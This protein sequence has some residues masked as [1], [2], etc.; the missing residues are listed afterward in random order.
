MIK[1]GEVRSLKKRITALLLAMIMMFGSVTSVYAEAVTESADEE[2]EITVDEGDEPY[3]AF[4]AD[5]T[6]SEK[7]KV[8]DLMGITEE[9]LENYTVVTVTNEQEHEYLGAYIPSSTIGSRAL[10][11]VLVMQGEEGS[12]LNVVTKN[13]TYCTTGMYENALATA[14]VTDAEVIV[15]GPSAISGTAALLGAI[16]AYSVMTGDDIDEDVIDAAVNE[17][18]I[19]G[20]LEDGDS[21]SSEAVEGMMA[22]LKDQVADEDYTDSE[23]E[24]AIEEAA[25]KFDVTLTQNQLDQIIELLQKI[26]NLDLNWDNLANQAKK[27]LDKLKD[28]GIDFESEEFVEEAKGFLRRIIDFIKNLFNWN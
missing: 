18:I 8:L 19:T 9:D 3:I 10:S 20:D 14:G 25:E 16:E 11:S 4:G 6:A 5:L 13:I 12:G 2:T 28:L 26:Q 1:S 27:A 7:A 21:G 23:L 15:A 22:Y 17:I 24:E